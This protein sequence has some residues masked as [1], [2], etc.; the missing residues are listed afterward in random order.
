MLSR[1]SASR[2]H[3]WMSWLRSTEVS[4]DDSMRSCYRRL[5]LGCW[6]LCLGLCLGLGLDYGDDDANDH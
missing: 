5:P 2:S 3:S 4:E 6:C 1:W